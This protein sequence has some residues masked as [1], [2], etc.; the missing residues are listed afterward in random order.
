MAVSPLAMLLT[1]SS[2]CF[3][4]QFGEHRGADA[5]GD[6]AS[7]RRLQDV[8]GD[9]ASG[10]AGDLVESGVSPLA[11]Q[12]MTLSVAD[13][14]LRERPDLRGRALEAWCLHPGVLLVGVPLGVVGI[15]LALPRMED[16]L[17]L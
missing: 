14:N 8:D 7:E 16:S 2:Q 6:V 9:L 12:R 1:S 3:A 11:S 13:K 10:D 4:C 15:G 5:A 17:P